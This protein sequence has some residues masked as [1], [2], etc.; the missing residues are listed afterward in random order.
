M[1]NIQNESSD[2]DSSTYGQIKT[3]ESFFEGANPVE[4]IDVHTRL[5]VK[6]GEVVNPLEECLSIIPGYILSIILG[7]ILSIILSHILPI[8]PG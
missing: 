4:L 5:T 8:I 1:I 2:G 3:F 6:K 7:H